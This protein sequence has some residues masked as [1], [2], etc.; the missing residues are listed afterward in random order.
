MNRSALV[1]W[2]EGN[3]SH[4]QRLLASVRAAMADRDVGAADR[5]IRDVGGEGFSTEVTGV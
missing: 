5:Q 4:A 1:S 2:Q 3:E